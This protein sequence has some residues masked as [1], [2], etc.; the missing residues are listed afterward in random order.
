MSAEENK[1][2]IRRFCEEV[3][4]QGKPQ[5]DFFGPGRVIHRAWPDYPGVFTDLHARIEDQVAEGDKVTTRWSATF[6]HSGQFV[7]AW[8]T[9]VPPSGRRLT[10][11][12]LSIDRFVDGKIVESWVEGDQAGLLQQVG[13]I[14]AP[15]A[16][17]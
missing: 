17:S 3:F 15:A 12:W 10:L 2:V 8:G 7:T 13:A 9:V 5:E 14:P 11:T 4:N 6:T 1:A 16:V